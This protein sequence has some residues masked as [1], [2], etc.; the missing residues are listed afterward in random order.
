ML[1][2]I[3]V[4]VKSMIFVSSP[5]WILMMLNCL[6]IFQIHFTFLFLI[7][8]LILITLARGWFTQFNVIFHHLVS[9]NYTFLW[10]SYPWCLRLYFYYVHIKVFQYFKVKFYRNLRF[11]YK[12]NT[13]VYSCSYWCAEWKNKL[14]ENWT[15]SV[16]RRKR[17]KLC[18]L[19]RIGWRRFLIELFQCLLWK[20]VY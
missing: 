18:F 14:W 20:H 16:L 15:E 7:L 6:L 13:K 9:K 12:R 2:L 4:I 17:I 11:L 1:L 3:I 10:P 5:C 8:L 19:F